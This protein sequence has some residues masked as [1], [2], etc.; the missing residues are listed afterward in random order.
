VANLIKY[1]GAALAPKPKAIVL[2][3][4]VEKHSQPNQTEYLKNGIAPSLAI[5]KVFDTAPEMRGL[6]ENYFGFD[7]ANFA[8][9][10]PEML[11]QF[12]DMVNQAKFF[13]E[14]LPTIEQHIKDYITAKVNHD[15]F[16][17][18]CI[19][20]GAAGMKSIDEATLQVF[21]E[22]KGYHLNREKLGRKADNETIKMEAE[23]DNTFLKE[24]FTLQTAL[25]IKGAGLAKSL[26][27]VEQRP[28]FAAEQAQQRQIVSDRKQRVKE[29]IRYGTRGK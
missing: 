1:V 19:K 14:M 5:T 17:A 16:L 20:S 22:H 8:M 11:G 23:R 6:F 18:N 21:L 12:T 15:K 25:Q 26:E 29:L 3:P 7:P 28:I 27:Q 10:T 13:D 4:K 9:M 2:Q 24:D